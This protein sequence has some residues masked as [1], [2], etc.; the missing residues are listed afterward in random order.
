MHKFKDVY[1]EL[2]LPNADKG[3][4]SKEELCNRMT[5]FKGKHRVILSMRPLFRDKNVF[6]RDGAFALGI[7]TYKRIIDVKYYNHSC[8]DRDI[9]FIEFL[10][11]NNIFIVAPRHN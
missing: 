3:M 4:I 8:T 11:N 1:Y 2:S 9:S 10:K 5:Q 6:L 7:D